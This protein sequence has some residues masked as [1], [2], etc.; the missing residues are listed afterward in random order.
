MIFQISDIKIF[1]DEGEDVLR[2]KASLL[3]GVSPEEVSSLKVVKKSLDARRSRP[4]CFIYAVEVSVSD[5]VAARCRVDGKVKIKSVIYEALPKHSPVLLK[6]DKRPV[7]VGCGPAGLFAALTLARKGIP[8][9]LLEM[10]KKVDER[11]VDVNTFWKKGILDESSNVHF[12][13]GGAGTF[14][15]GKL[16]TRIRSANLGFIKKTLIDMG[17]A[18]DIMTYAKPHIGTDCLREV[19]VNFR[20]ELVEL[21][22]EI[23]FGARVTDFIINEGKIE[24][25]VVNNDE[26][27]KTE[28]LVLAIGQSSVETYRQLYKRGVKLAAKPFAIGLRVEHPQELINRIQYGRWWKHKAL[29]PAD[30]FLTARIADMD[31]SVYTFCMCPGGEIIACSSEAGGVVTNGMSHYLR[32]GNFANSAVVVNIRTDDFKGD[33]PLSGL[34]F[35]RRWEE[36]AFVMGGSNYCAPAQR[37][38]DFI[39]DKEGS[40]IGLTSFVPGFKAAPL[41]EVLPPFVVDILKK[42]FLAFD[43]KMPGFISQEA[44]LIGVETRTSSPVRILRGENYQSVNVDGLYPCGE[45]AGYAGGIMSSALDGMRVAEFIASNQQ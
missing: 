31:R 2:K 4:P 29:P 43:R 21:G 14:S 8:V 39:E 30:Y 38:V 28:H 36:K 27:I 34:A 9:L 41:K 26:E 42:G 13:E 25:V 11:V 3:L 17:A 35:R 12:G 32:G 23:R 7:I 33:S 45:G 24:G 6:P 44:N 15:D 16:T 40:E 10:G 5:E 18:S 1:L 19:L 37:L 20:E 22:C